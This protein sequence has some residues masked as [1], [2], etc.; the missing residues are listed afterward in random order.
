M[1]TNPFLTAAL[2]YAARGWRVF[3]CTPGGK[4]PACLRGVHAATTDADAI[5]AW[6]TANPSANVGIACGSSGLYVVDFD[7]ESPLRASLAPTYVVRTPRGGSHHYYTHDGDLPNSASKMGPGV[8]TRGRG[9]YVVAPPSVVNGAG[10]QVE[11]DNP[12]APLPAWVESLIVKHNAV[13]RVELSAPTE[14]PSNA[15]VNAALEDE[16]NNVA[17]A[18]EGTRNDTLNRAAFS[19]G[20]LVSAGVLDQELARSRLM[21]AATAAGLDE[22]EAHKTIASG[23]SAGF[24]HP[25]QMTRSASPLDGVVLTMDGARVTGEVPVRDHD[26]EARAADAADAALVD[27][28]R[29]LGGACEDFLA[30]CLSTAQYPQPML[31]LGA[32]LAMGAALHARRWCADGLTTTS[33][34]VNLGGSGVGKGHPQSCAQEALASGWGAL[35]GGSDVSTTVATIEALKLA[36]GQGHGLLFVL[37]EYGPRLVSLL[38]PTGFQKEMRALLL[39][40]AT[41]GTKTYNATR[42]ISRGGGVEAIHAPSLSLLGSS[43]PEAF[44]RALSSG[45]VHDGFLPRHVFFEAAKIQPTFRRPMR[46]PVPQALSEYVRA[47][48]AGCDAWQ[49]AGLARGVVYDPQEVTLACMSSADDY[50]RRC[51]DAR[52][53]DGGTPHEVAARQAEHASRIALILCLLSTP[54]GAPPVV[55]DR[56]FALGVR[57]AERSVRVLVD[58]LAQYAAESDHERLRKQVIAACKKGAV[59]GWVSRRD[60]L[61]RVSGGAKLRDIDEVLTRL[62]AEGVVELAREGADSVRARLAG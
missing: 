29:A 19:L 17:T 1:T 27:D 13:T 31:S 39:V 58:G 59:D 52:R 36:A 40:N 9:G 51:D 53:L 21:D 48:K 10:Y 55:D 12:V 20:T 62:Q 28:V 26:A 22:T 8:D 54:P 42:S 4:V 41:V 50:R 37:D 24:K 60:V 18:Q 30:W 35:M 11:E 25:R 33:Y 44:H 57:I 38:D 2:G 5:T 45:A 47:V 49:R 7:Q 3:P 43:T 32:L 34:V 6:W 61:R 46:A 16:A 15:Y 23:L 56:H 14:R